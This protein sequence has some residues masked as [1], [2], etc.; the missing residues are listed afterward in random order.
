MGPMGSILDTDTDRFDHSLAAN[1]CGSD[2]A[3][4]HVARAM[5]ERQVPGSIIYT[6]SLSSTL[7][8]SCSHSYTVFKHALLGLF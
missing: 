2:F 1:V 5:V 7:G 6:E 4:N 8:G 3:I